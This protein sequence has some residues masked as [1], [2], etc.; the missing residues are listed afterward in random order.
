MSGSLP[1]WFQW[2]APGQAEA[3]D[4]RVLLD[5]PW[6]HTGPNLSYPL[7]LSQVHS[8]RVGLEMEQLGLDFTPMWDVDAMGSSFIHGATMPAPTKAL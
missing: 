3:R 1:K 5:F 2:L 6:G 4:Q 8:Q 7:L